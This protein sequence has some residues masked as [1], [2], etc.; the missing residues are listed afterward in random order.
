M[1]TAALPPRASS[2]VAGDAGTNERA[3][4]YILQKLVD[5]LPLDTGEQQNVKVNCV[6]IWGDHLYVGTSAGEILHFMKIPAEPGEQ[7]QYIFAFRLPLSPPPANLE[8]PPGVQKIL[9]LG[10]VER[11]AV[12]CNNQLSF[13]TLPELS[14]VATKLKEVSWVTVD[15]NDLALRGLLAEGEA[16]IRDPRGVVVFVGQRRMIRLLRVG[17]EVR[18]IRDVPFPQS[19][20]CSLRQHRA[21]LA[22]NQSYALV[23]INDNKMIPLPPIRQTTSPIEAEPMRSI[24]PNPPTGS[25]RMKSGGSMRSHSRTGSLTPAGA[26][27]RRPSAD[28]HGH[29]P[30]PSDTGSRAGSPAPR[31][32]QEEARSRAGTPQP[33]VHNPPPTPK[34]TLSPNIASPSPNEFLVTTGTELNEAAVG[35]FFDINGEPVLRGTLEFTRYPNKIL[36]DQSW[37]IAIV[38]GEHPVECHRLEEAAAPSGGVYG[39]IK[40]VLPLPTE[41]P[42]EFEVSS[43]G[44]SRTVG[45]EVGGIPRVAR[46]LKLVKLNIVEKQPSRRKRSAIPIEPLST[47]TKL[48]GPEEDT[49]E[50]FDEAEVSG[51]VEETPKDSDPQLP[52]TSEDAAGETSDYL[53]SDE[54]TADE[55]DRKRNAE[56][57]T[58]ATRI[59]TTSSHLVLTIGNKIYSM[60][61]TPMVL[62]MDSQ[63]PQSIDA[64]STRD[65]PV[66]LRCLAA[67]HSME[68]TTEARFHELGFIRQKLGLLLL[69][70]CLMSASSV[71]EDTLSQTDEALRQG[72]VDPR[73]VVALFGPSF[74]RDI[75]IDKKSNGLWVYG[76]IQ[77]LLRSLLYDKRNTSITD[78]GTLH[79]LSRYLKDWRK[80]KGL[81][82]VQDKEQVFAT[83]DAAYLRVL[84][85]LDQ[86]TLKPTPALEGIERAIRQDL[87]GLVDSGVDDIPKA[88]TILEEFGRLF[89]LSRLYAKQKQYRDVL[90]TWRRILAKGDGTE[91]GEFPDGEL[92]VKDYLKRIKDPVLVEEYGG[93]LARRNPKLGVQFF[94]D[95]TNKVQFSPEIVLRILKADAPYAV[96]D[97]LEYLV[98]Q[99]KN[100]VYANDFI[101]LFLD[102]IIA[103]LENNPNL[104]EDVHLTTEFYRAL[105]PPK[106]TYSEFLNDNARGEEWWRNRAVL[107]DFLSGPTPYNVAEVAAKVE[108]WKEVLI[109]EM[110]IF[111]S[112]EQ[113]HEEVLKMLCHSLKDFDTAI[114]YC[115]YGALSMFQRSR[116]GSIQPLPR[117]EQSRMLNILLVE[118][119]NISDYEARLEQT[120][121]LLDRFGGWLDVQHVLNVIPDNWSVQILSGFLISALRDLVRVKNEK[122]VELALL[123]T[124]N[125][126]VNGEFIDKCEEIG[127]RIESAEAGTSSAPEEP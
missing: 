75:V 114:N 14:P 32:S 41:S 49:A 12:I 119:L 99:K 39:P 110:V 50:D 25:L 123:K 3:A 94:T 91:N 89:V 98:V 115:L 70:I 55:A 60:L 28:L 71:S 105:H 40:Q 23:D 33:T 1:E 51:K 8:N 6:D 116:S 5:D 38:G 19:L 90:A 11:A 62:L 95:E 45:V 93:W 56:E 44:V 97:Y 18:L 112:K 30:V 31:A 80:K 7:S 35:L 37:V 24:S 61:E 66:I 57:E 113:N 52:S 48:P 81:E 85:I 121:S 17:A 84:L 47:I 43:V 73:L 124:L 118:F 36:I 54:A 87:Y 107:L 102:Q 104:K 16:E 53:S 2:L 126:K 22:N 82:S 10:P 9:L 76:G 65:V 58:I 29:S 109:A 59:S 69:G 117:D 96:K 106:P 64:A 63:L 67:V 92:I 34:P 120:S 78:R 26:A 68:P 20:E 21:C 83:I 101:S 127:P 79:F 77:D 74:R 111:Y 72:G 125:V 13:Y 88:I 103:D 108:P 27:E 42:S 100:I 86:T 46:L 15:E 4:P 122:K